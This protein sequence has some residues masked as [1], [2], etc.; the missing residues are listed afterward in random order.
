MRWKLSYREAS[1]FSKAVVWTGGGIVLLF[2]LTALLSP[3]LVPYNPVDY[4]ENQPYTSPGSQNWMGTTKLG[5]DVFSRLLAGSR[6]AFTVILLATSFAM[7]IG[8]PLGLIS[9]YSRGK[10]D[11]F[12]VMVM[13]SVYAFPSL[14][15]AITVAALLGRGVVNAALAI[16]VVYIPQYFRVIR[17]HVLSVREEVYVEAARGLGASRRIILQKYILF[18]VIQSVPVIL[19]LNAADA[20]LTLAGLGFLGYG[21]TP[22]TPEWGYDLSKAMG[23]FASGI[24]WTSFFPGVFIV[25]LTLGF[26]LLGEGL[27]DLLNPL[28]RGKK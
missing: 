4:E 12:L 28:L 11:R 18:N 2:L 17:N 23:D 10:M 5:Y 3:W 25:F 27:N 21:V 6:I 13:D 15:L 26:S 9:G 20:I 16:S 8:L 1:G 19:T 7:F 24:W 14:L 22:P